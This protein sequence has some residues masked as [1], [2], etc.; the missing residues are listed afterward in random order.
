MFVVNTK[1]T[2][3]K[4]NKKRVLLIVGCIMLLLA[5][6][7]IK[8]CFDHY[9]WI[10]GQFIPRSSTELDMRGKNFSASDYERLQRELPQCEITWDVP[11]Q[12]RIISSDTQAIEVT[13]LTEQDIQ[14]LDYFPELVRL[15]APNCTDYEELLA[16][17][18]RR[19]ECG[20]SYRVSL[21][22]TAYQN[23]AAV[24]HIEDPSV[25]ELEEL[26][27]FLPDVTLIRLS[28]VLPD[29]TELNH[30]QDAFPEISFQWEVMFEGTALD[31][32]VK[33]LDL[34]EK[35][36]GYASAETLLSWFP[37]LEA[38]DMRGCGLSDGEMM[39]LAQ[40]YPQCFFLWNMHI[41][42]IEVSTDAE[43]IDI[44]GQEME[45]TEQIEVLL[46]YFP[47]LKRVI[48]SFCGFDDET[49]DALNQR[50]ED[51]RFIWSV[52]IRN[53]YVRTDA[54]YFYPFTFYRSMV[55]DSDDLYPLRY[56]TDMVAIDIGHMTT[57]DNCEWAAFMP[58]LKYLVIVETAITDLT[59]LSNL[60]NL[61]FLEIFTTDITDYSPLLGCTALEDLNLGKT[62]GDP[63][64]IAQMTWLKN[65]WW[66]GIAGTYGLPCSNAPELLAEALPN[67]RMKF[68]LETPNV[69]NGW[70]QLDNYY[71]M[72]DCMGVFYLE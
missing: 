26:L 44:S 5:G 54:T 40:C 71:A 68:F 62:Y 50:Y 63:A 23:D 65:I 31:S 2:V 48:M 58:N 36:I 10:A 51:I 60:K 49:M 59:P 67:T 11:F 45:S 1:L 27:P 20:V 21:S 39:A 29:I 69:K 6:I 57:V 18:A 14:T 35:T 53:V 7:V 16:L 25:R 9:I 43:E 33:K 19:P 66:S 64:P 37:E 55:V 4:M 3:N 15:D 41:G 32:T 24:L 34:S 13:S 61:V 56:C 22:G 38:V 17:Q 28:G 46:P 30:L 72:R 70:R 8:L 52:K 42:D 47:N 12:G